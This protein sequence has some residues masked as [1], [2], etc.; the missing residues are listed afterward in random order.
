P[1][2]EV[3]G[4]ISKGKGLVIHSKDCPNL[5]YLLKISPEKVVKVLWDRSQGL[6]PVRIRLL[7]KDRLGILGEVTTTIG[8]LGANITEART[9]SLPSGQALMDFTLQVD[10]Y[11]SFLKVKEALSGLEGVESVQR[12]MG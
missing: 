3:Y 5:N 7:V 11:Q 2:E 9:K 6:H 8:R 4:V 12:L 10:N 1:G